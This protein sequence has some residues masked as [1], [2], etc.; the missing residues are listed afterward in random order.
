M[1]IVKA[2]NAL[3]EL[4]VLSVQTPTGLTMKIPLKILSIICVRFVV[5]DVK[6][7]NVLQLLQVDL[8]DVSRHRQDIT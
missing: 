4:A 6:L 1:K 3:T 8:S 5:L 7:A 2:G